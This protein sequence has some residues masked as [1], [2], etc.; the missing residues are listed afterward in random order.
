MIIEIM[1]RID[2]YEEQADD[3]QMEEFHDLIHDRAQY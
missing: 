1:K 3:M 2:Q